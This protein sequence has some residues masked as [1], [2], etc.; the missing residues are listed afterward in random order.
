[1]DLVY[2]DLACQRGARGVRGRLRR[3]PRERGEAPVSCRRA[4][5]L[6]ELLESA[7][8]VSLHA[9]AR[10]LDEAPDRC[11]P[12]RADEGRRH[13][14]ELGSRPADRR[15]RPRRAL[16]P[17]P[18][19][20]G[21]PSTCSSA[22]PSSPR[23]ARPAQRGRRPPPRLGHRLDAPRHGDAGRGQ[24]RRRA[25]RLA[26]LERR[27][28]APSSAPTRRGRRRASSMPPTFACPPSPP[29]GRRATGR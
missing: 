24:R 23:P 8:V 5:T 12:P 18:V 21:R 2:L 19:V 25:V 7:D 6:D 10:R 14:G 11:R 1:M 29:R 15:G 16:P 9:G 4:A 26:G 27:R 3:I 17:P 13:P 20:L 28:R 22:S